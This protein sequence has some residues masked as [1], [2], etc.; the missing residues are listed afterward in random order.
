VF[1]GFARL[2][3]RCGVRTKAIRKGR[4]G[5][6]C[7]AGAPTESAGVIGGTMKFGVLGPLLVLDNEVSCA[8][9]AP[10]QRQLL[11]FLLAHANQVMTL[12]DCI[13]ELW[14]SDLPGSVVPTL[15]TYVMHLRRALRR[16]SGPQRLVTRGQGYVFLVE[17]GEFDLELFDTR[18]AAAR[19]AADDEVA[20]GLLSDALLLWRGNAFTGVTVGPILRTKLAEL[21]ERRRATVEQRIEVDLRLGKHHELLGDLATLVAAHPLHEN[22]T[23]LFMLALYRSGRQTRALQ[24]YRELRHLL[25]D[26]YGLEPSPRVRRLT[27]AILSSSPELDVPAR[28]TSRLTLDLLSQPIPHAS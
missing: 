14:D 19:R 13:E 6:F 28:P 15:Q 3:P 12:A 1:P 11:A 16:T 21:E 4:E 9:S 26:R 18:T 24:V 23:R 20:S 8:P 2:S 17:P 22:F 7:H 10:K 5:L 25:A 27:Q